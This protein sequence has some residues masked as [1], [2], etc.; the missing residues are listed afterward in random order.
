MKDEVK[1]MPTPWFAPIPRDYV[2][3]HTIKKR[4]LD[5]IY[6]SVTEFKF[7]S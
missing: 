6:E 5:G 7:L 3:L 1:G 4:R 2:I